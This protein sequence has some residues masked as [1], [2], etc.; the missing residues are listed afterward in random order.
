MM[1]RIMIAVA[2][3]AV[4][5]P[6]RAEIHCGMHLMYGTPA[7]ADQ[8]LCRT[9]Y[10]SGYSY[11]YKA[12]LWVAFSIT[13]SSVFSDNKAKR[14]NDF[15]VDPELPID[16]QSSPKDYDEPVFDQGHMAD[17]ADI[18]FTETANSE[19]FLMSNMVP[20]IPEMNRAVFGKNGAWGKLEDYTRSWVKRR[21]HLYVVAG[22]IYSNHPSTIGGGVAVPEQLYKIIMD[23]KTNN[24]IAFLIPANDKNSGDR[25]AS[26][27]ASI[28]DIEDVTGLDFFFELDDGLESAIESYKEESPW[29]VR[30]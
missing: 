10:V 22:A 14:Q 9:G 11:R 3:C 29:P 12:P 4:M 7:G 17:S 1:I 13:S 2:L 26:Y 28:D 6:L 8:V 21:H 27:I 23:V 30:N 16:H 15:R 20:Q 19:T 25:L 24:A 18:D 5:A